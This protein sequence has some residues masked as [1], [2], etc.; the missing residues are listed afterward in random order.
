[1]GPR[2]D[3]HFVLCAY[4]PSETIGTPLKAM[5]FRIWGQYLETFF[6][7]I[8]LLHH[9]LEPNPAF[10]SQIW[11]SKFGARITRRKKVEN[12][13]MHRCIYISHRS[14]ES[15]KAHAHPHFH[16]FASCN[17]CPKFEPQMQGWVQLNDGA[18]NWPKT[19]FKL[20]ASNS[21]KRIHFNRVL[22][23]WARCARQVYS[24]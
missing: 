21:H 24:Y 7:P 20:L 12:V 4:D 18:K 17:S 11:G 13:Y 3:I 6:L 19:G 14:T 1:M 5:S 22:F 2:F 15:R 8:L 23:F 10:T 9:W 16:V